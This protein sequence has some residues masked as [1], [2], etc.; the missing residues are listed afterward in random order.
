M[1]KHDPT[2]SDP[3]A[4]EPVSVE[5]RYYLARWLVLR[6]PIEQ[7]AEKAGITVAQAQALMATESFR[8]L[9]AYRRWVL[10]QPEEVQTRWLHEM[11]LRK[12]GR[13]AEADAL[14]G[15][16]CPLCPPTESPP[17]R[18]APPREGPVQPAAVPPGFQPR[19]LSPNAS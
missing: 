16:R 5:A 8:K 10:D 2:P 3:P 17:L 15:P 9:L 6:T 19:P 1:P 14:P 18:R 7:A 13:T 4:A 11:A 12:L